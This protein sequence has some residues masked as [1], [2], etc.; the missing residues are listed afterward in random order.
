M[1]DYSEISERIRYFI[2]ILVPKY[3]KHFGTSLN[4]IS[5]GIHLELKIIQK[6]WKQQY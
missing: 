3:E 2:E 1:R 4:G 6:R 5:F